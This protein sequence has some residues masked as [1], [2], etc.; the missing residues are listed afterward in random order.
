MVTKH[1]TDEEIQ[2][3]A[4]DKNSYEVSVTEHIHVCQECK[5]KVEVYQ[6]LMTGIHLQPTPSFEFDLS[7]LVLEKLPTQKPK[8]ANDKLLT[9]MLVFVCIG[10]ASAI[11][12]YFR[13]YLAGMFE[14]VTILII[15]MIA[16]TAITVIAFL[17]ADMYKKFKKEMKVLDLY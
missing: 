7:K 11:F 16:I 5:T 2:L 4:I 1:L 15:Y 6:S 10:F 17:V 13:S 12:Y 8:A 14:G 3:F 9:W